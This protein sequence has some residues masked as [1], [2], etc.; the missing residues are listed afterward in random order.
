MRFFSA[1]LPIL[2]LLAI[3]ALA[4]CP[5][6]FKRVGSTHLDVG[7]MQPRVQAM[8]DGHTVRFDVELRRNGYDLIELDGSDG[9]TATMGR[10][11]ITLTRIEVDEAPHYVGQLPADTSSDTV[12]VS[13]V[14]RPG[15][16]GAPLSTAKLPPLF[17]I[18]SVAPT[19]VAPDGAIRVQLA[20]APPS[21]VRVKATGSCALLDIGDRE[22]DVDALTHV[23]TINAHDLHLSGAAA[24]EISLAV[25]AVNQGTLDPA[26][27]GDT[28]T[29][30]FAAVQERVANVNV[31][32]PR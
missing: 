18:A 9:I 3:L 22:F 7:E 2:P 12:L 14:R 25:K 5:S 10:A 21:K 31:Q 26:F 19:T 28:Y 13:L 8:S 6:P 24:C 29:E 23:L 15:K 30:P 16:P 17:E 20:G 32:I 27:S 1:I 4:G 11:T